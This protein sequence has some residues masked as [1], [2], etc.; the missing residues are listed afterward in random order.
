MN[1]SQSPPQRSS[2]R[3]P[4][5]SA[6]GP[7]SGLPPRVLLSCT[8]WEAL[9]KAIHSASSAAM[10]SLCVRTATARQPLRRHEPAVCAAPTAW[11]FS[12]LLGPC[13]RA[14]R[15]Q[16][17]L[18][19]HSNAYSSHAEQVARCST[20]ESMQSP[21][22]RRLQLMPLQGDDVSHCVVQRLR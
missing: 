11:K 10:P 5:G 18:S 15:P 8:M 6:C 7:L 13:G 21:F 22:Q 19:A 9:L 17:G 2:G 16:G 20:G 14:P 1:V 3:S 12:H 4:R